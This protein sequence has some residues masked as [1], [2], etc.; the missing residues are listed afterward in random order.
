MA[1]VKKPMPGPMSMAVLPGPDIG[2]HDAGGIVKEA[3]DRIIEGEAAPPW[4]DVF[5]AHKEHIEETLHE[6]HYTII[7]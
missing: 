1:T 4:A 2:G 5:V 7:P 3:P 6:A